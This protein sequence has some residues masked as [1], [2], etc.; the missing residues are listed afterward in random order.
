M[1]GSADDTWIVLG[2]LNPVLSDG[3]L[4]GSPYPQRAALGPRVLGMLTTRCSQIGVVQTLIKYVAESD[5]F[6]EPEADPHFELW[7]FS[8][9]LTQASV[10]RSHL[11]QPPHLY[12]SAVN[13]HVTYVNTYPR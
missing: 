2:Q 1:E 12:L 10:H 8:S 4:P 9:N 13:S 7:P 11:P 5:R 6:V 3:S